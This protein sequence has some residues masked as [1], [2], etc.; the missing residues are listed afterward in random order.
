VDA[1]IDVK[2]YLQRC[3]IA[4]FAHQVEGISALVNRPY[5]ALFDEMGAGKTLQVIVAAQILFVLGI[6]D[7]VIVL[8]PAPV[9]NVWF[10][11]EL[12][13]LTKHLWCDLR[14]KVL[15]YHQK[16]RHWDHG[17]KPVASDTARLEWWITNYDFIRSKQRLEMLMQ[18]C[19]NKTLLVCDES[20]AIK[21]FKAVQTKA[22]MT[23][24]NKCGRAVLLNGTPISNNPLD[25]Y[26]QM[27]ALDPKILGCKTYYE[28]RGRY[29]VISTKHG[30]PQIIKW[31]NL[32][33][34][35]ARVAPH[36]LQRLKKDCIDLPEKL[37]SVPV[38][39][40]FD[41]ESW[42]R[43]KEMRD[44]L[45]V[46]LDANSMTAAA[47]APV[48]AMRLAQLTSGFIG[49]IEQQVFDDIQEGRPD[50]LPFEHEP[51]DVPEFAGTFRYVSSEKLD[52]FMEWLDI[53]LQVDP[54]LKLLV[55]TRFRA[56]LERIVCTLQ[57]K[58][59]KITCRFICGGQKRHDRE[60]AIRL[61]DPRTAPEGPAVMVGTTPTGSLGL[62]LTA[63]HTVIYFS[64]DYSIKTRKQS[65]DRTHRPGQ[66][67]PVSYSDI[68]VTGPSGQRTIDHV[69]L[70]A[71][72][73]KED[74]SKLTTSA[75]VRELK[76][77]F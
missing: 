66:R 71:L 55:W 68:I 64:N 22:T 61:L 37:E 27:R 16:V 25:L 42:E 8:A 3:Q 45:C 39:A 58:K 44:E 28:A 50:D 47:Q 38:T 35:S 43:Y 19:S 14:C 6:I 34:L 33:D 23:L 7:R 49:G 46:W 13:E 2:P 56:E 10:D 11:P 70:M 75:W 36:V 30:F 77:E 41:N 60:E 57:Q 12:G 5:F 54:N 24:R 9:R 31:Q 17:P 73:K 29:A 76:R 69:I 48:K 51:K 26:S 59:P 15:E 52:A 18:F 21:N 32:E 62:N 1:K 63:A 67:S 4:P 74:L 53:Q 65:E 72:K 20:I 40:T